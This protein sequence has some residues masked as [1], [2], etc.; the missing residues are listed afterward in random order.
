MYMYLYNLHV[1]CHLLGVMLLLM[2]MIVEGIKLLPPRFALCV[3]GG[4]GG[5]SLW[6]GYGR[7]GC[8][9]LGYSCLETS[10]MC[11]GARFSCCCHLLTM[12]KMPV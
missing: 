9:E 3:C 7:G 1:Q 12:H 6:C 2:T 10:Q 4:G 5:G 11:D 8:K